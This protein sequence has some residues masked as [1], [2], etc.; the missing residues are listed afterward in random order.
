MLLRFVRGKI[1]WGTMLTL[2]P[3]I[4]HY[5]S[6]ILLCFLVNI[7]WIV[8]FFLFSLG[9]GNRQYSWIFLIVVYLTSNSLR[10]LL[11]SP[12]AVSSCTSA[13]GVG[14][15]A[16]LLETG[17]SLVLRALLPSISHL[18]GTLPRGLYCLG[19][20][21]PLTA[22]HLRVQCTLLGFA[23]CSL[24]MLLRHYVVVILGFSLFIFLLSEI[25]LFSDWSTAYYKSFFHVFYIRFIVSVW[26]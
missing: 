3:N 22:F 25:T 2:G 17:S 26:G 9:G 7:L 21:R 18:L 11:P 6:M 24:D 23:H 12:Q 5:W 13:K 16:V 19:L 1:F 10:G 14:L 8:M 4:L 20:Q 15:K